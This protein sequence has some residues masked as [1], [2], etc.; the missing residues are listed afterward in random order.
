MLVATEPTTRPSHSSIR[1]TEKTAL[2]W[3]VRIIL[4]R[5]TTIRANLSRVCE[6]YALPQPN[7]W[8]LCLGVLRLWHRVLFRTETVGTSNAGTVRPTWRA[9]ALAWRAL[10]LPFLLRE[11]AVVPLDFTGLGSSPERLIRHL[12]GAHHDHNQFV[13]DLEVLGGYG[14]LEQLRA[15]VTEVLERDD[16]RSRWLRDLAV[17]EGYHESLRGAVERAIADGPVMSDADA[18]DPDISLRAYL[19][20]CAAQPATPSAT[21]AAWRAG[22]FH[23]DSPLEVA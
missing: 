10:R 4:V 22:A 21:W 23:F 18:V 17:F 1:V 16:E 14:K 2:P 3:Y 8:Q 20:W 19:A 11:G 13:Y 15:A 12:L 5:P 9:R 6:T 7:E